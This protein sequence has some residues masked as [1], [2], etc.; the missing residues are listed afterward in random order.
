MT[1]KYKIPELLAEFESSTNGTVAEL[2]RL[3]PKIKLFDNCED[4]DTI[5]VFQPL[6]P[7]FERA[8]TINGNTGTKVSFYNYFIDDTEVA[9]GK[10]L[11][12]YR[13]AAY[14]AEARAD[15]YYCRTKKKLIPYASLD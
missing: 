1:L 12:D 4:S 3:L 10:L 15:S 2:K 7:M 9:F 8:A 13:D 11:E 6:F 14:I 5:E